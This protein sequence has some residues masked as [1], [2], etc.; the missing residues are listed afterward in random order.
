MTMETDSSDYEAVA[1]G[2]FSIRMAPHE[3]ARIKAEAKR[4]NMSVNAFFRY[5]ATIAMTLN[6]DRDLVRQAAARCQR[7][8]R[9]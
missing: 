8:A 7:E 2:P 1:T 5:A 3:L 6:N 4:L 9:P